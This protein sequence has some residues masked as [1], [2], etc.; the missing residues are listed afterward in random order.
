MISTYLKLRDHGVL[1][2]L[3][4]REVQPSLVVFQSLWDISDIYLFMLQNQ[5]TL[6]DLL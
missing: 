2:L 6:A 3:E 1:A 4:G 5:L